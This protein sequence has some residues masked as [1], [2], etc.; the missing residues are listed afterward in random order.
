MLIAGMV[1]ARSYE[2][3]VPKPAS[4]ADNACASAIAYAL[5]DAEA[6]IV[7]YIRSC[8]ENPNKTVCEETIRLMKE[9]AINDRHSVELRMEA[10]NALNH[11]TFWVGDQNINSTTFG[12][13]SSSFF[14][15][16]VVQFGLTYA[17]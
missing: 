17:F 7:P 12:V 8:G 11:P 14:G 2:L 5:M 1:G 9:V 16:R 13:I 10:F 3:R 4:S 6:G 15:S